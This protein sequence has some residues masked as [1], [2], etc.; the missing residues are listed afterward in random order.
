MASRYQRSSLYH[1]YPTTLLPSWWSSHLH[2]SLILKHT[3]G[4]SLDCPEISGILWRELSPVSNSIPT[5]CGVVQFSHITRSMEVGKCWH[6]LNSSMMSEFQVGIDLPPS[7]WS[8]GVCSN[9][10][11]HTTTFKGKDAAQGSFSSRKFLMKPSPLPP[12]L[13]TPHWSDLFTV[14]P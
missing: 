6:W 5:H 7:L 11:H 12:P 2:S 10:G 4:L 1:P 8:Q 14:Y 9:S 13:L 3:S